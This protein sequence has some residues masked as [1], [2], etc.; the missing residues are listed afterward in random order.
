MSPSVPEAE[1]AY[2]VQREAELGG[3]VVADK[4]ATEPRVA[5][6]VEKGKSLNV[7]GSLEGVTIKF[8]VDTGAE[9][10]AI[11]FDL[12]AKLPRVTRASFNGKEGMLIT[13]SGE[14]V[15]VRGP[16]SCKITVAG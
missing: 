7:N 13:A 10:I 3:Q 5:P 11:N 2:E 1:V 8:L 12:L 16:L 15:P 4:M 14:R 9:A 6:I